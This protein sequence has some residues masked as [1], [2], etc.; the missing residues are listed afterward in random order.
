MPKETLAMLESIPAATANP[1]VVWVRARA[2][3]KL[4][5]LSEADQTIRSGLVRYPED[6]R[7]LSTLGEIRLRQ[8]EASKAVQLFEKAAEFLPERRDDVALA[9]GSA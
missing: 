4:G 7:S 2:H 1:D 9:H 6:A 5:Q 3:I 8:H